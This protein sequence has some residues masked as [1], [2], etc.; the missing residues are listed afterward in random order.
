M[1]DVMSVGICLFLVG[2]QETPVDLDYLAI[3]LMV[4][5]QLTAAGIT[6]DVTPFL[7][8]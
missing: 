8:G 2:F 6:H 1:F 5:V 4:V 7:H 3:V